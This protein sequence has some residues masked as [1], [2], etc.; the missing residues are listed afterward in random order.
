MKEKPRN[1]SSYVNIQITRGSEKNGEKREV[2]RETKQSL[3]R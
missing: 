2:D 3:K 1:R